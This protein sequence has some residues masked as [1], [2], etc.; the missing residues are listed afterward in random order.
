MHTVLINVWLFQVASNPP[1]ITYDIGTSIGRVLEPSQ[2]LNFLKHT[3]TPTHDF[4]FPVIKEGKQNRTF[5]INW[6][7]EYNWL[8]YSDVKKG[9]FC[10]ACVLFAPSGA[11][12]G[13]Q[14]LLL[15]CILICLVRLAQ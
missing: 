11:G 3:W 13:S 1:E 5:Q 12:V 15:E 9:A 14:V 10:K 4:K 7:R 6:L 8:A 2:I